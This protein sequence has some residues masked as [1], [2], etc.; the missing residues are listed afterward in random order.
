MIALIIAGLL[1][2]P[3]SGPAPDETCTVAGMGLVTTAMSETTAWDL[4]KAKWGSMAFKR[5]IQLASARYSIV[6]VGFRTLIDADRDPETCPNSRCF[7]NRVGS[8]RKLWNSI[9]IGECLRRQ[10]Q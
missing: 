8:W 1:Q 3:T 5:R 9:W 10:A 4:A 7:Q 6:E 2:L